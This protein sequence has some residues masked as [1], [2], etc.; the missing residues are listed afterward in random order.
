[1]IQKIKLGDQSHPVRW[2]FNALIKME[3]MLGE[4]PFVYFQDEKKLSS[5]KVI[6]TLMYCGIYGG[7]RLIGEEMTI[8]EEEEGDRLDFN[9]LDKYVEMFTKDIASQQKPKGE[10][11]V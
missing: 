9:Q 10:A 8:T 3:E 7:Y 2:S 4:S 6:R 5:P 11:E 1:M